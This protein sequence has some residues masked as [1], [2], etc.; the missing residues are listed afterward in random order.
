M[1]ETPPPV[2]LSTLRA[3]GF[4]PPPAELVAAEDMLDQ[5]TAIYRSAGAVGASGYTDAA[6]AFLLAAAA[7]RQCN[8]GDFAPSALANREVA[9]RNSALAWSCSSDPAAGKAAFSELDDPDAGSVV[10]ELIGYLGG[11]QP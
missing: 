11:E 4:P 9:Y 6:V 5:A 10:Q 1:T 7:L 8:P 3:D 2:L